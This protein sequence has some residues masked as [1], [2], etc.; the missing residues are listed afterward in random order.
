MPPTDA[1]A[2]LPTLIAIVI[3][4]LGRASR[5]QLLL[6][7]IRVSTTVPHRVLLLL[8]PDDPTNPDWQRTGADWLIV[9]WEAGPGDFAKKTNLGFRETDEEFVFLGASDLEFTP[10]WDIAALR[11][12]EQTGVGVIGTQDGANPVVKKG[13]HSTHPLVR[14]AY[15]DEYGG[16]V[17]GSGEVYCQLY[18]H[19][20]VD[21][22]LIETAQARGQWA[23]AESSVVLHHHPMY[24]RTA[25][26]DA[27]Y[28]KALAK[29]K[30]D[31]VLFMRRRRLWQRE[32]RR[33]QRIRAR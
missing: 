11:V 14:R 28:E 3:P 1:F 19:Q 10:G 26:M 8:S 13:H 17:D 6:S 27:T 33:Q 5:A 16:T 31:R 4:I 15:I 29:G 7:S 18:D 12:A 20:A 24:I 2:S 25:R 9:P 32:N 21:N 22:E 23:F 30:E